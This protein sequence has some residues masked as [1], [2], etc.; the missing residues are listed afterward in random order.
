M[1]WF[2]LY[3][4]FAHDP[5][6]QAMPEVMQRRLIMLYCLQ[7]EGCLGDLNDEELALAL[8]VCNADLLH[9]KKIFLQKK[10]I[11]ENWHIRSWSK[12]QM[13]S[14]SAVE[15]VRRYR[16]KLK[17]YSNV[18][19]T[20]QDTDTDTDKEK[21]NK[22][23]AFAPPTLKEVQEYVSSQGYSISPQRFIDFYQAKGWMIGKNKMKDWR[24]AVRGWDTRGGDQYRQRIT[25]G[26]NT[27]PIPETTIEE[28]IEHWQGKLD[29]A[30]AASIDKGLDPKVREQFTISIPA[31]EREIAALTGEGE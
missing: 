11:T 16:E 30:K 18:T 3:H 27:T 1:K 12:R 19:V 9:T 7:C 21:K 4:E 17:R 26:A 28:R 24:A 14:D 20:V 8:R 10:F 6:V 31:Y 23:G 29:Q 2:R 5:K 25:I 15:R 22:R 13:Y